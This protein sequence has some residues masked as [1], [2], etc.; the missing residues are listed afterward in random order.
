MSNIIKKEIVK[1]N[2]LIGYKLYYQGAVFGNLQFM[3]CQW[4]WGDKMSIEKE[5]Q[6]LRDKLIKQSNKINQYKNISIDIKNSIELLR[7]A[8]P[9]TDFD[10]QC[11]INK[12]N[13]VL[14]N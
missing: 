6:M 8:Y 2:V 10:F 3:G 14:Q 5:N 7:N 9:E 1:D 4:V 12:L 11:N 13:S